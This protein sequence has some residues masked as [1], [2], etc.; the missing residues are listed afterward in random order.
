MKIVV[1]ICFILT[2]CFVQ[3]Q[4]GLADTTNKYKKVMI[5]PFEPTRYLCGIQRDLAETSNMSHEQIVQHFRYKLSSSLQ[6]EFLQL[7]H[8]VSLIH[9]SDTLKDL[10][11]TYSRV[12]YKFEVFEEEDE[13]D[14]NNT[15][16]LKGLIG[17]KKK[18]N[19]SE[20]NGRIVNGQVVSKRTQ[21]QKYAKVLLQDENWLKYLGNKYGA[22]LFV[23]ITE[24]DIENDITDPIAFLNN[25]YKRILKV[26]YCVLDIKGKYVS[27]GIIK[28]TFP[29]TVNDVNMISKEF[30]PKIAKA[31]ALKLPQ[32]FTPRIPKDEVVNPTE[33]IRKEEE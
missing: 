3:A 26:N 2:T 29:N 17:R 19:E 8:C 13:D 10:Y 15:N 11:D 4:T 33:K 24:L 20:E 18:K 31:L 7:Y 12:K 32:P 22:D 27:E 6:D 28:T 5:V 25:D 16:G 21:Q 14:K 9:Y 23:F 30:F 1:S